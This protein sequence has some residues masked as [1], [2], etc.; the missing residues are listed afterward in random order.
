MKIGEEYSR[1][2]KYYDKRN[3]NTTIDDEIACKGIGGEID[4]I[5]NKKPRRQMHTHLRDV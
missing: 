3:M 1:A 4:S 2:A 5:K